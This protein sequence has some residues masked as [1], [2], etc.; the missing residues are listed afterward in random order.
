MNKKDFDAPK[1]HYPFFR[2]NEVLPPYLTFLLSIDFHYRQ[3]NAQAIA[4]SAEVL[5][6]PQMV[7][8]IYSL[9]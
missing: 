2:F 8:Y 3:S 6:S 7:A 4:C 5:K 9:C 1:H